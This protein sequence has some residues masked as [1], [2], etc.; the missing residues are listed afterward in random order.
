VRKL[1]TTFAAS[2]LSASVFAIPL[3][4]L[5]IKESEKI[6]DSIR[7]FNKE[8]AGRGDTV[9][10]QQEKEC[11]EKHTAIAEAL[12]KFVILAHQ[13]LDFLPEDP[14]KFRA[15]LQ[16]QQSELSDSQKAE[17]VKQLGGASAG[18]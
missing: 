1:L 8:C 10:E 4:V 3:A 15:Q 14:A 5:V 12:A 13:E 16:K 7:A 17:I 2:T 11:D 6:A 9:T 18:Y